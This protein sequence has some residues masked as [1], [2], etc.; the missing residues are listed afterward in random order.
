MRAGID[1]SSQLLEKISGIEEPV[2]YKAFN[3]FIHN[4]AEYNNSQNNIRN[5]G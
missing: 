4:H 1:I 5:I 2:L 3:E